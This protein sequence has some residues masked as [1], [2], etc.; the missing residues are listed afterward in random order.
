MSFMISVQSRR[1]LSNGSK[2]LV[3]ALCLFALGCKAGKATDGKRTPPPQQQLDPSMHEGASR[4]RPSDTDDSTASLAGPYRIGLLFQGLTDTAGVLQVSDEVGRAVS[5]FMLAF[6]TLYRLGFRAEVEVFVLENP[7][8]ALPELRTAHDLLFYMQGGNYRVFW[9]D[10]TQFFTNPSF[11]QH[12]ARVAARWR[13]ASSKVMVVHRGSALEQMIANAFLV[14]MEAQAV[15]L[16][17]DRIDA[18]FWLARLKKGQTNR[19]YLCSPDERY[20]VNVLKT[21]A[22]LE[23][24]YDIAIAGLPNWSAF[25]TLDADWFE[26]FQV[27]L[28]QSD[29]IGLQHPLTHYLNQKYLE[30]FAGVPNES[31]FKAFDHGFYFG[32][33]LLHLWTAEERMELASKGFQFRAESSSKYQNQSVRLVQFSSYTF[34]ILQP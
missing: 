3:F 23:E 13:N 9:N 16:P 12:T 15:D 2:L 24:G 14:D 4:A 5:G 32:G 11:E 6:D 21:L 17:T 20:V 27:M 1:L 26:Q 33:F 10:S 19:I 34:N 18:D 28:S 31:I 25:A 7:A 30:H 22:G 8:E 29:F